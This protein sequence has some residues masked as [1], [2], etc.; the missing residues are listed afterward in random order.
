MYYPSLGLIVQEM[1]NQNI[2][3]SVYW[4]ALFLE[5]KEIF[6]QCFQGI[7]MLLF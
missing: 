5:H 4:P 1:D 2:D 7:D 6:G 3:N